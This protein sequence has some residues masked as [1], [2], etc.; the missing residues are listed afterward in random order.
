IKAVTLEGV[1]ATA[2]TVNDGTYLLRRALYV[3]TSGRA[4]GLSAIFVD[5]MR[6]Q[7]VQTNVVEAQSLIP[8]R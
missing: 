1:D 5:Y 4:T 6:S 2:E 8:I 7:E 3:C